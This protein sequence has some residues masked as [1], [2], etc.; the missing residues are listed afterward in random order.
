VV[1]ET[2]LPGGIRIRAFSDGML[3]PVITLTGSLIAVRRSLPPREADR[4]RFSGFPKRLSGRLDRSHDRSHGM[5]ARVSPQPMTAE[6]LD[7][8]ALAWLR[9]DLDELRDY[10]TE[11][12]LYSPL[13]GELIRGREAVV[14]RFAEVLADD[15][16]CELNFEPSTVSGAFGICRWRLTGRTSEGASFW[17]EGVDVYE[18]RGG[19]IRFKDVYQKG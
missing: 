2:V 8:F 14:R 13:S 11:D 18:F 16:G 9:C 10:L 17:V 15:R 7:D 19:L 12:A 1:V 3:T 4:A 6:R 5:E